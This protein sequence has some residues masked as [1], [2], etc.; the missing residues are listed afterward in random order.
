MT[1]FDYIIAG[2]GCAGLSLAYHLINSPLQ[3]KSILIIDK[4]K[5]INNDR[6]WSFWTDKSTLFDHIV[7]RQWHKIEIVDDTRHFIRPLERLT[8]KMIRAEDFYQETY[9]QLSKSSHVKFLL[10]FIEKIQTNDK[11]AS[12]TVNGQTYTADYI[13]D[14]RFA[15]NSL[16][17]QHP[18]YHFL[19]QHFKGWFIQSPT[20]CFDN[21]KVTMFDFRVAQENEVRF[22][23]TLPFDDSTA[24]VEYT[25]FSDNLLP[26]QKY[27]SELE[28]YIRKILKIKNYEILE[29][30]KGVIPMT[31]FK[32]Q[33]QIGRRVI[34]IGTNGGA[35]KASTGYAFLRIQR[36]SEKIVRSLMRD[37]SPFYTQKM[38]FRHQTYDSLL[39][40]IMQRNG[41]SIHEIFM[42]LFENNPIDRILYF[43][44]ERSSPIQDFKIM[45]SVPPA[46]FLKSIRNIFLSKPLKKSE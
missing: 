5:K 12:L 10:G 35:C 21:Q 1:H 27:D 33:K 24:L 8:Y 28:Q 18:D 30:E 11:S 4:D 29:T 23:Y 2:G 19:M 14:S 20:P 3:N 7:F 16:N 22:V 44:D 17:R 34:N 43:L 41:G 39:L 37:N 32:F 45:N 26:A 15:N 40:N 13:F 9:Q 6:T 25:V 31:D 38:R 42:Q 46:P 36:E